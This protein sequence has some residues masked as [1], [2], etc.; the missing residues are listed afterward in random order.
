L[1]IAITQHDKLPD[2]ILYSPERNW[3][4]LIEAVTSHGPVSPKRHQEI[5]VLLKNCK[6]ERIY[7]TAFLDF[8]AFRKYA[9]TSPGKLKSGLPK[10]PTT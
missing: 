4:Y 10:I 6:A 5:E 1:R 3:L 9:A 8:R 7:V 2:I